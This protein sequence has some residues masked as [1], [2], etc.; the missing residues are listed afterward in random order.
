[1]TMGY[2]SYL[3]VSTER[4]GASGLGVD[5]QRTAIQRYADLCGEPII[6]EMVEVESGKR[7][8]RPVLEDAISLCRRK[9][10]TLLVAKL[11]RLSRTVSF[12]SRLIET[13]VDFVAVD[14]PHANKLMIHVLSAFAE[15]ERD[16]IAARTRAALASA[17][18][19]GTR[20]GN[21]KLD[22]ARVQARVAV[23]SGADTF[24]LNVAPI[25]MQI[26]ATG[27]HTLQGIADALTA[28]GIQTTRGGRW[29]PATV[30]NLEFRFKALQAT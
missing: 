1:M 13:G 24:C 30:R 5:A 27:I 6:S 29:H 21:P 8:D 14:N 17:K 19:R 22:S 25:V 3:R 9:K 7:A 12:M 11:D 16:L 4:Q 10:A 20:L 23:Q 15:H 2:V 28:R 18:E 26:R